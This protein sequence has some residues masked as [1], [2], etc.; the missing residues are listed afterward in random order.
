MITKR[1]LKKFN[2]YYS[3]CLAIYKEINLEKIEKK[4]ASKI[5]EKIL[6]LKEEINKAEINQQIINLLNKNDVLSQIQSILDSNNISKDL[7][8]LLSKLEISSIKNYFEKTNKN[9]EEIDSFYNEIDLL[10]SAKNSTIKQ[11]ELSIREEELKL[12]EEDFYNRKQ[13]TKN[14]KNIFAKIMITII[15][16]FCIVF[17]S[18]L[19]PSI[20]KRIEYNPYITEQTENNEI[21]NETNIDK[22]LFDITNNINTGK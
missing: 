6:K 19:L 8:E 5:T 20:K 1:N 13:I 16:V 11:T 4:E 18:I 7:S 10:F 2:K 12:K 17:S 21:P 3:K 15:I 9:L 22:V 14:N